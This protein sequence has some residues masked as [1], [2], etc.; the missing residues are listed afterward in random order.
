MNPHRTMSRCAAT[1]LVTVAYVALTAASVGC[2]GGNDSTTSVGPVAKFTPDTPLGTIALLAGSSSGAS[3]DVRVTVTN[4]N[5]FFGAAF[6]IQYDTTALFFNGMTDSGSFLRVGLTEANA[7]NV[8]FDAREEH[9]GEISLHATRLDPNVGTVDVGP[10]SDLVVLNFTALKEI[11]AGTPNGFVKFG[12]QSRQ[13]QVCDLAV[14]PL[15]CSEAVVSLWS[16]GH[17]SAQ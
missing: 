16:G 3:I 17:V 11:V 8:S 7:T 2:G 6:R 10:A 13:V 4:I 5:D 1:V 14:V 9:L 12:D 15:V